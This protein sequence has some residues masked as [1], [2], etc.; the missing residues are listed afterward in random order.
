VWLGGDG[1]VH[2]E[3]DRPPLSVYGV[4]DLWYW[5]VSESR[6]FDSHGLGTVEALAGWL[7]TQLDWLARQDCVAEFF[8]AVDELVTQLRPVT[9]ARQ[10]PIATCPRTNEGRVC[11]A[12]LYEPDDDGVIACPRCYYEWPRD[13][14]LG[15]DEDCLMQV[16]S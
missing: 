2:R 3:S 11:R 8:A 5:S 6:G 7:D 10:S 9:G 16:A 13:K 1:R 15:T 12:K 14:W 4:L